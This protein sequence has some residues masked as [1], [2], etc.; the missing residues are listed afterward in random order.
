MLPI[1]WHPNTEEILQVVQ[2]KKEGRRGEFSRS[3]KR[4]TRNE[5]CVTNNQFLIFLDTP[6]FFP[7]YSPTGRT[8]FLGMEEGP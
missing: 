5:Y 7:L 6:P 2:R 8:I 4:K 3:A 1:P